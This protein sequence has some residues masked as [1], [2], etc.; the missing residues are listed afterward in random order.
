MKRLADFGNNA[1]LEYGSLLAVWD[2]AIPGSSKKYNFLIMEVQ[3]LH[4][5]TSVNSYSAIAK[6]VYC[7]V[8]SRT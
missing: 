8:V 4:V 5:L 7:T 3:S 2:K 1:T 6:S